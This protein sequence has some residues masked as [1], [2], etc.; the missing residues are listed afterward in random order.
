MA[1]TG[2]MA[3]GRLEH[4]GTSVGSSHPN[5]RTKH[6]GTVVSPTGPGGLAT[7]VG[8]AQQSAAVQGTT[9]GIVGSSTSD[10]K[11]VTKWGMWACTRERSIKW[12]RR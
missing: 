9:V 11:R 8:I 12:R 2:R 3:R 5:H 10:R 6:V 4:A 1:V 7:Y